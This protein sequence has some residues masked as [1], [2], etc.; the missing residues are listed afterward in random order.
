MSRA[1]AFAVAR[2]AFEEI[3]VTCFC[4]SSRGAAI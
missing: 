1:P 4:S 2:V 3:P